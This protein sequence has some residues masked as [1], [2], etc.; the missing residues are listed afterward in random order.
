MNGLRST[1]VSFR[2]VLSLVL[3]L[4]FPMQSPA[5]TLEEAAT[6]LRAGEYEDALA[7]FRQL[8]RGSENAP[9]I[10]RA[11]ARALMEVGR[12]AEARRLVAG[13]GD[14][15]TSVEL[16]NVLGEILFAQ[17]A[18]EG[19]E[20]SFRRAIE[21]G[22]AD[23]HVARKNLGVLLWERGDRDEA[24]GIFDTFI[25]LYNRRFGSLSAEDLAAVGVAVRYLGVTNPDLFEDAMMAFEDA[26]ERDPG[27]PE[28]SLLIGELLLEKYRATDAR[29]AFREVLERNPGNPRALLGHA[30][31]LDFEGVGGAIE[32]VRRALEVNSAY[33]DAWAFLARLHLKTWEYERALDAA[34]EA[35]RVNPNHLEALS[36]LAATHFLAGDSAAYREVRDRIQELNP[37]F[38]ELDTTV[39]EQA[40]AQ[41]QYAAAAEL[42][43]RA[44]AVDPTFWRAYG[45]LGTNQLRTGRIE[46]GRANLERAF[47]GDPYNPWYKNT[48]DL[49]DTFPYYRKF[50]TDHF[51]IFVHEREADLLGPYAT[52]LAEE[53]YSALRGRYGIDPP[54]PVRLEIYPSH[55]DF[56]VR[57]LGIP[58]L[59]A[60]GVSFGSTLVMDSPSA[61][62]PG[63]FN[64]ASTLWHE[65][66]H[67]FHLAMTAHEV[68]RWF[69]E[70]LA[71]LEQRRA[72]PE[73]G[74]KAGPGWLQAFGAGRLHPVSSLNEGF[75]RPAYPEQV[76][77]S[78]YQ[79]SLV[80][81]LIEDRYGLP[82]VLEMM[83]GYRRGMTDS[84]VFREVLGLSPDAFDETFDA[85]V[86]ERW[87]ARIE[88]VTVSSPGEVEGHGIF[89]G[90][91]PAD[92]EALRRRA[93]ENPGSFLDRLALGKA[94][95]EAGRLEEAEGELRTALSLFPE[96]G[97]P[98]SPY[99]Y[100]AR[101]HRDREDLDRA[102]Q[103]LHQLG[104][105]NESLYRVHAEEAALRLEMG[106]HESAVRA[107]EKVVE[108]A[109]FSVE[110]HGTLAELYGEAG[111]L[112]GAVL[113]RRALLALE[114]VNR[115]SAHYQLAL[116]LA[117]AGALDE[118]RSQVL[119]ALE[120]A[121]TYD[122]ALE[123]L[124]ELRERIR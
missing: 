100:L 46:E 23:R 118:A 3:P 117:E 30:R 62:D 29:G 78:Y 31:I 106:Q 111:E 91:G 15:A 104:A 64:W 1:P 67:A 95:F 53:A 98:D 116:A 114:P 77:F 97:G 26:A 52:K 56:S 122:E 28:P 50:Q 66:A 105:L 123:L 5:Q 34:R 17:G 81:E 84:E 47:A 69:T 27:A 33:A 74:L 82:A 49:L 18:R 72:R 7:L 9:E 38:P 2:W 13:A 60:L 107:L 83:R 101:I 57:T 21:G 70:G 6:R 124:L 96:Y 35:L 99:L 108:I 43:E 119:R 76:V 12:H 121:P 16:E 86:L 73:W 45:V 8:S 115:A 120:L 110:P 37:V 85:Y 113:E 48:L 40:A 39:A 25:D 65:V 14:R 41:H 19:A 54:T 68:P 51:E 109:P 10:A 88:A 79:A 89:H 112:E 42:A 55:A 71:V 58:G 102:A 80:L 61:R 93:L 94:L 63:D 36:A 90:A 92:L 24:L 75:V 87:G 103:A 22:A 4:A 32:T 44:V 59:G 11:H 20:G